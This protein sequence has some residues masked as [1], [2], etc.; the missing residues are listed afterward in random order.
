[1]NLNDLFVRVAHLILLV[2]VP[3]IL[4]G[5]PPDPNNLPDL[6]SRLQELRSSGIPESDIQR[7]LQ[8]S[9]NIPASMQNTPS[10]S[11]SG[12]PAP[13]QAPLPSE[14]S[15]AATEEGVLDEED[16]EFEDKPTH[17]NEVNLE[18][19]AIS[20]VF[21]HHVLMD[22]LVNFGL[23]NG[24]LTPED[25]IIGPGD[26]FTITVYGP[27]ELHE[28]LRVGK[29]GGIIRQYLGK[30][31]VG[32]MTFAEAREKLSK[33]YRNIV[34]D[35]STIEISMS[36]NR[37]S[38]NVNIVGEVNQP[39]AFKVH[40]ST[41]AF[42]A[43]V[44]AGGISSIGSVRNIQIKRKGKTVQTLDLYDFLING[45]TQ[46]IYLQDNDFIYV[47]V[48]GK[49]VEI[50]GAVKRAKAYELRE[51][52][53]LRDLVSF[54]GGLNY[55]AFRK[56]AKVARLD[57]ATEREVLIDISLDQYIDRSGPD[58]QL[59]SGDKLIIRTVNKGA[60]NIV[61]IYGNV[62]YP[63]TY[64]LLE[65]ERVSDLIQRS[66]GLGIDAF[67]ETAYI[68]RIVPNSSEVIYL[69]IN[70]IDMLSEGGDVKDPRLQFFDAILI[71]SKSDFQ[72]KRFI[73]VEGHVRNPQVIQTSP[74]M[75]LK[76][77]L[78]L[79]G[80]IKEDADFN[81]VELSIIT[82]PNQVDVKRARRGTEM[83]DD[84]DDGVSIVVSDD[85]DLSGVASDLE[86]GDDAGGDLDRVVQRISVS[87]NWQ[88]DYNLDTLLINRF[89][90]VMVYSK[91]DFITFKYIEVEGAVRKPG[92][93]QLKVGMTLKDLLYQ[94]GGLTDEAD[95]NEVELYRDI[96]LAER[97][98]F[99]LGTQEKE[100]I[101]VNI[102]EDWQLG[103][104]ADSI[105]VTEFHK[106]IIRS[107]RDFFVPGYVIV[108]GLVN[109]PDT[110]E[111]LPNMTLKDVLY[112][113]EGIQMQAD[114]RNIELSRVIETTTATGE[115][116]PVPV[117]INTVATQQD[118]RNDANLDSIKINAFDM[119]H[120][121]KNA[122]FETQELVHILGEVQ[123]RGEYVKNTKAERLSSIVLRA[124]GI[125]ELADLAG[126]Y[127]LRPER[128][129][130]AIKLD[131]ALKRPNSKYDLPLLDGDTLM[132]PARVD[133]VTMTGNVLRPNT[134]VMFEP[135]K[136]KMK[137]YLNL[138]GG[139]DRRSRKK[140]TTVSYVDGRVKRAKQFL[141]FRKYPKIEQGAIVH[142]PMKP[143]KEKKE[144]SPLGRVNIQEILASATAI[145]T[146]YLLVDRTLLRE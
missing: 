13:V 144:G 145:L 61:Q 107:E 109:N 50:E 7:I 38:I 122:A 104:T 117:V 66:G 46:P 73:S 52:E 96:D 88:N 134:T 146:F 33:R 55:D 116:I 11:A 27:N 91:Y 64:Q 75:T 68:V 82:R 85:G 103:N 17:I 113:A 29:D 136:R 124:G 59:F 15:D 123:V 80:G 48:Q 39:G 70:L 24:N 3:L 143:V 94:A 41:P 120:I 76:D 67:M 89:D 8:S 32:G 45:K 34:S 87:E 99:N 118:W 86:G 111:V 18:E 26:Q 137:Y 127:I 135:N 25:Y 30:I 126:A 72:D 125:T 71:F 37:R 63:G 130:I 40:A 22:T 92:K 21:G 83:G 1:M 19:D 51:D 119:I 112:K 141:V 49:V 101:R 121:R 138:A 60:F 9:G 35:R 44:M 4:F 97:G 56:D 43:L 106:M 139:F 93:Y 98:T 31:Y 79:V 47:P 5:Q 78:F 105:L 81:N 10:S 20:N 132:I 54:A 62:E 108:S 6:N 42:N 114:F 90:K 115:I 84:A 28:S 57:K 110:F 129:S 131:K 140:L 65:N 12:F 16:A 14:Q 102:E 128:G 74:T 77:L 58:Y 142:I 133:L 100:I 23:Y 95:V 53:N 36:A 2:F 69:P